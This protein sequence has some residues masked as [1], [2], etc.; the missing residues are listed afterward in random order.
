MVRQY[1]TNLAQAVRDDIFYVECCGGCGRET[2]RFFIV[3]DG[4]YA[5]TRLCRS[6]AIEH[7]N[8]R[9]EE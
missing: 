4:M 1:R 9:D 2:G 5:G 6:C 3:V 8:E 7:M